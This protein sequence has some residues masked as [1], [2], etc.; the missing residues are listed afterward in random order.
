[1]NIPFNQFKRHYQ[2]IQSEVEKA[3]ARVL[4]SGWYIL[5][6]EVKA[7]EEKF[8]KHTGSA[9][10]ISVA[11]GTEALALALMA[12]DIGPGDEVL[13]TALTAYPTI[14]AIEMTGA[15]AVAADV[16]ENCLLD[17]EVAESMITDKTKAIIPVHLYGQICDMGNLNKIS[18]KYSIPIIEDCAQSAGARLSDAHC[19]NFGEM[20]CFSFYPTKNLGA[21]GDAGAVITNNDSLAQKLKS[22]RNYG[23]TDRYQ[24]DFAGINSRMDEIQAAVLNVKLDYLDQWNQERIRIAKLYNENIPKE[25]QINRVESGDVFHLF[26]IISDNRDSHMASLDKMGIGTIIHYPAPVSAQKAY[27]GRK[28]PVEKAKSLCGNLLSIPL[29]PHMEDSEINYIIEAVCNLR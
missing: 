19:G 8:A 1:M 17:P 10:C 14:T 7:F 6:N 22:L 2:S 11:N 24:H 18:E 16:K 28:S 21:F 27:K 20:G 4:Q 12:L 9:H 13:T 5:G 25:I 23:Q 29:N 3:V 26:P 15:V